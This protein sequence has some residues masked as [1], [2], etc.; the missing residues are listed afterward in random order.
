MEGAQI[1]VWGQIP[2][3]SGA[4]TAAIDA[5]SG[6][7]VKQD[8][9]ELFIMLAGGH[10]A[11]YDNRVVSLPL[12]NDA[13]SWV[14]RKASSTSFA[15]DSAYYPDGL[16]CSRHTYVGGFWV[17]E[18][19][20]LMIHGFFGT[21][22]NAYSGLTVDGFNPATNQWDAAGT[23]ANIPADRGSYGTARGK[24]G[25]IWLR[26]GAYYDPITN[27][28]GDTG[29]TNWVTTYSRFPQ[30]YD[31][32]REIVFN[33]QWGDGQGGGVDSM[34]CTKLTAAGVQTHVTFNASAA[35][36]QFL[37][38]KSPYA[39]MA[40]DPDNDRFLWYSGVGSA[41]GRVYVI[42]PNSG[43][44]WD[45][46]ILAGAGTLPAS[47]AGGSGLN[48]RIHYIPAL[49]CIICLPKAADNIYFLRTA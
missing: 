29:L 34:V 25:R 3:T 23:W 6:I 1:G 10:G 39:G 21:E 36:T 46:S 18:R 16:P 37:A 26:G 48:G 44:V 35:Y 33:L 14:L 7:A 30:V 2:N 32:S 24:N 15:A 9:S 27:T 5:F 45:M 43:G 13:P 8:T 19:N 38:D 49:K 11:T 4:G 20:R 28:Y 17:P 40:Y 47:P 22:P 12:L 31:P 41:A 42:T